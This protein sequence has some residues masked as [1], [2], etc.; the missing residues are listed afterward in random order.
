M[1]LLAR[2]PNVCQLQEAKCW[3]LSRTSEYL[4]AQ[5]CQCK[6]VSGRSPRLVR[7]GP[8]KEAPRLWHP[9]EGRVRQQRALRV[10][11]QVWKP[12]LRLCNPGK[13]PGSTWGG[14]LAAGPS[15]A[16]HDGP[17]AAMATQCPPRPA[18][19][20]PLHL[21]CGTLLRG[22]PRAG[23]QEARA[24]ALPP[25]VSRSW[26]GEEM[27][28]E[29]PRSC[30]NVWPDRASVDLGPGLS[31]R[32]GAGVLTRIMNTAPLPILPKTTPHTLCEETGLRTCAP[33]LV[34]CTSDRAI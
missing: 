5:L 10:P 19:P 7:D 20:R 11:S 23:G 28:P 4:W 16:E 15:S 24:S 34:A 27:A 29:Q 1:Y 32:A 2:Q 30:L 13:G 18:P 8:R 22:A 9:G 33:N 25:P 17:G 14:A 6:R 12:L 26:R 21:P 31:S 3:A